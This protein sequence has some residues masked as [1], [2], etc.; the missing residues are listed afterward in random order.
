MIYQEMFQFNE[1]PNFQNISVVRYLNHLKPQE[2]RHFPPHSHSFY[3]LDF[4]YDHSAV[5]EFENRKIQVG[6]ESLVFIPPLCIHSTTQSD[7]NSHMVLQFSSRLLQNNLPGFSDN[8]VLIPSGTLQKDGQIPLSD[9]TNI[10]MHNIMEAITSLVPAFSLRECD[11]PSEAEVSAFSAPDRLQLSAL[12]ISLVAELLRNDYLQ[13][14]ST[15]PSTTFISQMQMLIKRL[16]EHPEEKLSMEDAASMANMGYSHFCRAFKTITGY[17]YVDFCNIQRISRAKEILKY[18]DTS[19]TEISIQ[20]NF[21][22]ISYFNRVFKKFTGMS[23]LT[24]RTYSRSH[25]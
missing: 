12:V 7:R 3:E 6:A 22:S 23:P 11:M 1:D 18:T 10:R 14:E 19:V 13:I 16:I 24:Y 4:T 25:S 2:N 9:I 8:H 17:S 5:I 15:K 21:G 20:L